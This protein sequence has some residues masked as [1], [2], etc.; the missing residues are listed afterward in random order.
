MSML[1]NE[2]RTLLAAIE[3]ALAAGNET[4]LAALRARKRELCALLATLDPVA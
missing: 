3:A 2:L 1:D 4:L